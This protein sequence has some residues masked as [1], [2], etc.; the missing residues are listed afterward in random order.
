MTINAMHAIIYAEDAD[1]TRAFFKDVLI[2]KSVD[3]GQGRLIFALPPAELG[4]HPGSA[5]EK[6]HEMYLMCD[7]IQATVAQLKAKGVEFTSPVT[8]TGWG[9]LTS[10]KVPGSTDLSIYQPKHPTAASAV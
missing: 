7:D 3:A 8:D 2:L 5:G 1:K 10:F 4:I 6:K 9:L